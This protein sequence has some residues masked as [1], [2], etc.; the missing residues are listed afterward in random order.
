MRQLILNIVMFING[1][2]QTTQRVLMILLVLY[3]YSICHPKVYYKNILQATGTGYVKGY[4]IIHFPGECFKIEFEFSEDIYPYIKA[5]KIPGSTNPNNYH[6]D[7]I[8]P[9]KVDHLK[10]KVTFQIV[11]P[12]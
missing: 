11:D 12:Q 2:Q 6:V 8:D 4:F 9:P 10:A 1:G 3:R 7:I 5:T